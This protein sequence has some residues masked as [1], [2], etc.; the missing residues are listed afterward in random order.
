MELLASL[1]VSPCT[2]ALLR[3]SLFAAYPDLLQQ[4]GVEDINTRVVHREQQAL[5][6]L[7][8]AP[9]SLVEYRTLS[10]WFEAH[11]NA[12]PTRGL[13]TEQLAEMMRDDHRNSVRLREQ[14]YDRA[15]RLP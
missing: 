12:L 10:L 14:F 7:C 9:T 2:S 8:T 6:Q 11:G 3:A 13:D 1:D 15:S 5:R 4:A